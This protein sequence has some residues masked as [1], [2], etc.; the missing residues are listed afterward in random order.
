MISI[1]TVATVI[2]ALVPGVSFGQGMCVPNPVEVERIEGIVLFES[3]GQSRPLPDVTVSVS[4]YT[5][6]NAGPLVSSVSGSDGHFSISKAT[7]GRY[8][9]SVRHKALIGFTTELRLLPRRNRATTFLI[10][11]VRNDPNKPCGGGTIQLSS[12]LDENCRTLQYEHHNQV[13]YGPLKVRGIGGIATDK[14][15]VPVPRTCIGVFTEPDH[16]LISSAETEDDGSFSFGKLKPGKYRLVAKYDGF[17]VANVL[18][19]VVGW[20][21]DGLVRNRA[22]AVQLRPQGIDTTSYVELMRRRN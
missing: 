2:L 7:P 9:L 15:A 1:Q 12:V 5:E 6:P 13:D 4:E 11:T 10:T 22:L 14:E 19:E 3:D 17:G 18:L 21:S 8:W 16:R 20:P